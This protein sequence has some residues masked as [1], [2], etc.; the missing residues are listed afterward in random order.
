MHA[1]RALLSGPEGSPEQAGRLLR[2][3]MAARAVVRAG[4]LCPML[5]CGASGGNCNV[6]LKHRILRQ[7]TRGS[8]P[9]WHA[10]AVN[11]RYTACA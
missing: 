9:T 7:V 8:S 6:S 3:R 2:R 11:T 5:G 4:A 10:Q 1:A